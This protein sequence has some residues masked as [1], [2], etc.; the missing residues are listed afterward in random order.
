MK[1]TRMKWM[2]VLMV[3]AVF[4]TVGLVLA[5]GDMMPRSLVS[6]GGGLVSQNSI[7]LHSAIGQPAIGTVAN[8]TI[9]CSGYL[10]DAAA[11]PVS[12]G[13]QGLFLPYINR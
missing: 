5:G 3:T 4:L 2:I 7:T 10:C 1:L 12:G 9:L 6:S 11:P 13:S 8:G